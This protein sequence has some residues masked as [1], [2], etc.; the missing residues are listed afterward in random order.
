MTD[1]AKALETAAESSRQMLSERLLKARYIDESFAAADDTPLTAEEKSQIDDYWGRYRFA[2][3]EIDYKSFQTFK[4]RLGRFDVRHCPGPICAVHLRPRFCPVR[5]GTVWRQK[6]YAPLL[7]PGIKQP[8]T[9]L[10]QMAG[11]YY[12]RSYKP[13]SARAAVSA[14]AR[15]LRAGAPLIVKVDKLG[16]GGGQG[17]SFLEPD[18]TVEQIRER[19]SLLGDSEFVIQ[20][21]L[22]QSPFMAALNPQSVNTIRVCTLLWKGKVHVLAALVRVGKA[23]NRVDNFSAGGTIIGVDLTTGTLYPRG[24]AK[25]QPAVT[26]LASGLDLD[27]GAPLVIPGFQKVLKSV[28]KLHYTI[29]YVKLI[30][31]DIALDEK[32][33]PVFIECNFQNM[34]QI[35]EAVT[36]PLFGELLDDMLDTYLNESFSIPFSAAGFSCAE[37]A[38]RVEVLA[39]CREDSDIAL[40][41]RIAGKPVIVPP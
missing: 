33:E 28:E 21:T 7:Y 10:R 8:K 37:Y 20:E 34:I 2:Y 4:N 41:Q 12:N 5:Y 23:G 1:I 3:P 26:T 9:V 14:L 39:G 36:G 19:L 11:L 22:E 13:I 6:G 24:Y 16:F 30:G 25:D 17:V 29:P 32:D 15:A 38:D 18:A 40:P 35:H 27:S 31:W